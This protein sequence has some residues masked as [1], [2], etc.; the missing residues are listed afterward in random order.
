MDGGRILFIFHTF[1]KV[2]GNDLIRSEKQ[3]IPY[4]LKGLFWK[5]QHF[6]SILKVSPIPL[7]WLL[8]VEVV[9]VKVKR[10]GDCEAEMRDCC[11]QIHPL[12]PLLH[13]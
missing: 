2:V 4:S 12:R 11:H 10:A 1:I 7:L 13:S 8:V 5:I 9:D 3:R 6:F